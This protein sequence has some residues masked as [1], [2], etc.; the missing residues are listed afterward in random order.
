[1]SKRAPEVHHE[2]QVFA[3]PDALAT[4]AAEYV[5]NFARER[6]ASTGRFTVALSGGETPWKML[7]ALAL[8]DVPWEETRIYQVDERIAPQ[9]DPMRNRTHL[10][11]CLAKVSPTIHAMPV[12]AVDLERAAK[13]Y[14][15]ELPD[16]IDLV[17]LG[18]GVDGHTASL[19]P[20]DRV[21]E[22]TDRLIA[23]TGEYQGLRRMTFTFPA[24]ALADQ[25]LWLV[26]G[27]EKHR[28]L[29]MLVNGDPSIP[30]GRAKAAR[31]L[32]MAD[33]AAR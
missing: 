14:G 19:V 27:Q 29:S 15:A 13:D 3:D 28:P 6:V 24:I 12:D 20:G 1:M 7:S 4:A 5:A 31:S 33:Q 25:I 18:L 10:E 16:R 8:L 22:V 32:I 30:A 17:H 9:D 26:T 21:L 2:L 11:R 23:V